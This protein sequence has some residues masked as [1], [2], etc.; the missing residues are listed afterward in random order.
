MGTSMQTG[1]GLSGSRWEPVPQA[2]DALD[3]PP[4]TVRPGTTAPHAAR[5]ARRA[6]GPVLVALVALLSVGGTGAVAY[7]VSAP[8]TVTGRTAGDAAHHGGHDAGTGRPGA[9]R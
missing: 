2:P 9:R 4:A 7:E 5:R 1:T 6:R 8:G 3:A